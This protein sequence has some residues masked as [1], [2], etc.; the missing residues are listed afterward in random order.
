MDL[1]VFLQ[2]KKNSKSNSVLRIAST[3]KLFTEKDLQKTL[4][5]LYKQLIYLTIQ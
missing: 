1:S 4:R 2:N 5:L 3:Y